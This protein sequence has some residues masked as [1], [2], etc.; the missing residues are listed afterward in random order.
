MEAYLKLFMRQIIEH[1]ENLTEYVNK[2][3]EDE[4]QRDNLNVLFG[5]LKKR[6][7]S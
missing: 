7:F 4:S 2:L 3:N 5:T 1:K 6:R